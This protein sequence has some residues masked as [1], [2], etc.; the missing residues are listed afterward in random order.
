MICLQHPRDFRAVQSLPFCYLCAQ[1]FA[2]GDDKNRDH[3]PPKTVFAKKDRIPLILPTHTACNGQY[4]LI[5]EKMGQVI[6]LK[7]G[8]IPSD[9]KNRHLKYRTFQG[10]RFTAVVNVDIHGAVWRWIVGFHAA[11]YREPLSMPVRGSLVLPFPSARNHP[12]DMKIDPVR[13][14]H[15]MFVRLIKESRRRG[16]VDRIVT[17]A[18]TMTYECAWIRM[19]GG[20][21]WIC[22]FALDVYAWKDLGDPRLGER[23]CAGFYVAPSSLPPTNAAIA[24]EPLLILPAGDVLDPF[25]T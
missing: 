8:Y 4:K 12:T 1:T 21:S 18:G 9:P 11:L 16:K 7:R 13:P 3:V 23:G 2:A 24:A 14:Q 17:N 15:A 6:G 19:D 22:M 5:D 25:G 20:G 10:G